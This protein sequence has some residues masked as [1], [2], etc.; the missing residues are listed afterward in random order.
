MCVF[1]QALY[2]KATE[3]LWKDEEKTR[4]IILRMGT[5]HTLFNFMGTIGKR[6]KDAGLRDLAVESR[7]ITEGSIDAT[8][9]GRKYNRAIRP[10]KLMFEALM[11]LVWK[12][13]YTWIEEEHTFQR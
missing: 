5:F 4:S 8:L 13:F 7:I 12:G 10:H 9:Q 11:R 1:D 2:A 3:I 6:F